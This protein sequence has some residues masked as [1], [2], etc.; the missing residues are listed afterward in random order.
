MAEKLKKLRKVKLAAFTH[1]QQSLQELVDTGSDV[2]SMEESLTELKEAFIA[3]EK[4][5]DEY[6]GEIDDELVDTE[7]SYLD[8]PSAAYDSLKLKIRKKGK[9][10]KIAEK[11]SSAKNKFQLGFRT[12][13]AP[14]RC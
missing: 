2:E 8:N 7:N 1:K 13:A 11:A 5:H 4:V 3:V 9:E 6:I 14:L 10:V 12:S